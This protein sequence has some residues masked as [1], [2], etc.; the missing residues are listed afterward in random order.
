MEI[1][2]LLMLLGFLIYKVSVSST[3]KTPILSTEERLSQRN[4]EWILFIS[5][6][7]GM[8]KSPAEKKLLQKILDDIDEKGLATQ[9]TR[10]KVLGADSPTPTTVA[11]K[12]SVSDALEFE[13]AAVNETETIELSEPKDQMIQLDNA[14]LLLYFGAF[15]FV[16]SVGL[17]IAFGGTDGVIRTLAVLAVMIVLYG[18][19]QWLFHSKPKLEQAGLAFAGMGMAIAP[20]AGVAAYYY[21]FEQA[22][23]PLVWMLTSLLCVG[24]Y[25]HALISLKRPLISYLLIFTFLSLFESGVSIIDAPVYYFGWAMALT[26]IV[27]TALSRMKGFWPELQESS[28]ASGALFLPLAIFASAILIGQH[29]VVQFGISLIIAA[30]YYGLETLATKDATQQTNAIITQLAT[31]SGIA[32]LA[33]GVTES[34]NAVAISILIVAIAQLMLVVVAGSSVLM[35]HFASIMMYSSFIGAFAGYQSPALVTTAVVVLCLSSMVTWVK[36]QR[37]DA[38]VVFVLSWMALP[39]VVGQLLI[40]PHASGSTQTA[41]SAGA[42]VIIMALYA[43]EKPHNKIDGWAPTAQQLV[44]ISAGITMIVSFFAP[45]WVCVITAVGIAVCLLL[46][47]EYDK[48]DD[49]GVVGGL[50]MAGPLIRVWEN[51]AAMVSINLLALIA[52]VFIALRHRNEVTRWFSTVLWLLV[53]VTIASNFPEAWGSREYAWSYVLVMIGLMLSRS[54]ARGV[55]FRSSKIP[56]ASYAHTASQSYVFGYVAA[57]ILAIITA[58]NGPNARVHASLILAFMAVAVFV[59]GKWIEKHRDIYFLLPL[60]LQAVAWSAMRP[61]AAFAEPFLL[62]SVALAILPYILVVPYKEYTTLRMGMLVSGFIA[63]A[64]LL[65]IGDT[66]WPMPFGLFVAGCMAY[67]EVR[68]TNQGNRE[69]TASIPVL[70]TMWLMWYFGIRNLQAYTHV[71]AAMFASYAYWRSIRS[72][73]ELSDQYLYAML[74]TATV[75]LALQA[76]SGQAGGVYGW[77]LLLEQIGF[78]LLGMIIGR[79]FVTFWGL[80]VAI[81]AVLYQLRHL[82]W[83]ALTVLAM[84]I[85]GL[86]IYYLQKHS[87]GPAKN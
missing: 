85:I 39:L 47:A 55:V 14:S 57:A 11:A 42:L 32:V 4:Q 18:G 67:N 15:L 58:L 50:I 81:A 21:L 54:I 73:R 34:W 36:Q 23:G 48:D 30:A 75:P 63:P 9:A 64:S 65:I 24:M 83:A 12:P 38:F 79:K 84:F 87:D 82:G 62:T 37:V 44:I 16:A 40:E 86:A 6:Y 70:A 52:N 78:M 59:I 56:L 25:A 71:L 69:L 10:L 46:L 66:L 17:F 35:Q 29:G 28:R 27:L 60:L 31:I 19:G 2:L 51:P 8:I 45:S 72:E 1:L 68:E 41:L 5:G 49:W 43:L 7:L 61:T 74:A 53:P 26:G 20:L 77:W 22:Q 13:I 80:Y 3:P 33:Y 76:I